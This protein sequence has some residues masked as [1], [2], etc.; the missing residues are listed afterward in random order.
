MPETQGKAI[1][2]DQ[3]RALSQFVSQTAQQGGRKIIVLGPVEQ[4]NIPAANAL[5]KNLEEP[6]GDT[7]LILTTHAPGMVLPTIRSRCQILSMSVPDKATAVAWLTDLPVD[8]AELLLELAGGAPL[9]VKEMLDGDYLEHLHLFTHMLDTV[10]SRSASMPDVA[11]VTPCL[12]LQ[13]S[14]ITSWWLQILH[15]IVSNK[16]AQLHQNRNDNEGIAARIE[17]IIHYARKVNRQW[18]FTFSDKLLLLRKQQLQ[19]AN[20]NIQLLLEEL[21]LDW[22]LMM[23]KSGG[24]T[25]VSL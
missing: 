19:G 10:S 16:Q 25:S 11:V 2:I 6:A 15:G 14:H 22:Q 1:K 23:Q 17:R 4:L 18:L 3:I 5:L 24:Q 20:P 7:V 13:V 12:S 9:I 8:D 21:L